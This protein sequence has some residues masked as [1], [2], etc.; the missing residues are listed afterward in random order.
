MCQHH[1]GGLS[2]LCVLSI[3]PERLDIHLVL[4]WVQE[5]QAWDCLAGF[6]CCQDE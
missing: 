2:Q 1:R 4:L 6:L 5:E 3:S